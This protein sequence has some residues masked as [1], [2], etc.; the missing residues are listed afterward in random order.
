MENG[1]DFVLSAADL[2]T[3]DTPRDWKYAILDLSNGMELLLK[4]R[5]EQEHWSLLFSNPDKANRSKLQQ[6]DFNSVTF[7]Q[8]CA[9]LKEIVGVC[10]KDSDRKHLDS[11]RKLRNQFTHYSTAIDSAA[12]KSLVA[13]CMNFCIEFCQEEGMVAEDE[14]L[15][16]I[17][18]AL[19]G[20]QEFIDERMTAIEAELEGEYIWQCPMCW[21]SAVI[22]DADDTRCRFCSVTP[23][24]EELAEHNNFERPSSNPSDPR[25]D[26]PLCPEC[27]MGLV[28]HLARSTELKTF[29]M[30]SFCGESGNEMVE[31]SMC[32]SPA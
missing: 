20:F 32:G 25:L 11:I 4:A 18:G 26:L 29:Y 10:I 13:K 1:L 2:A 21:Q 12:T 17:H 3:R 9:R 16:E 7:D 6:G 28:T 27:G 14:Q 19:R 30:C 5:L 24:A 15:L 8:A 22:V 31:C 23:D